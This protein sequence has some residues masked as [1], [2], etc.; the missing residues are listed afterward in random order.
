MNV[1][2]ER[3]NFPPTCA[4]VRPF[5]HVFVELL[6]IWIWL[7]APV[8]EFKKDNN[9]EPTIPLRGAAMTEKD[10]KANKR[11][12]NAANGSSRAAW[13]GRSDE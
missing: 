9:V 13:M 11:W 10:H 4:D 6:V 1:N 8:M 5:N 2:G 3:L 12:K 7:M